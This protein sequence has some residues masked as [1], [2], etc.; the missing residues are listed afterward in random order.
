MLHVEDLLL[1]AE[2]PEVP[3]DLEL[4]LLGEL[5]LGHVVLHLVHLPPPERR[6]EVDAVQDGV[7]R[8]HIVADKQQWNMQELRNPI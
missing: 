2:V 7:E 8:L 3:L 5:H 4:E 1:L 6:S